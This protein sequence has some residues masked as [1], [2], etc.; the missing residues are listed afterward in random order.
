MFARGFGHPVVPLSVIDIVERT[1]TFDSG[2][3]VG[4]R[5]GVLELTFK[6]PVCLMRSS[7][8][9]SQGYQNKLNYFP[10]FY[11]LMRSLSYR[12]LTL[13]IL[14]G[15][16]DPWTD[17]RQMDD[18]VQDYIAPSVRALLMQA[19]LRYEKRYGTP[20]GG[21]KSVYVMGG[22]VGKLTFAHVPTAYIPVLDF[23]SGLG[24]GGDIQYGLGRF[25]I[26]YR[27]KQSK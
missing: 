19:D 7:R 17:R 6:T 1:Y 23:A 5:G 14:Y 26:R 25:D 18:W 27:E 24:V 13:G 4:G 16:C 11:Q 22:Y 2:Q 12:L 21:E 15:D 9:D 3:D 8:E 10:S 20:K